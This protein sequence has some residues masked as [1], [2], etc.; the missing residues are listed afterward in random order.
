MTVIAPPELH[1]EARAALIRREVVARED[2]DWERHGFTSAERRDWTRAG[3]PE[4]SAHLAAMC[5]DSMRRETS[6][7]RLTPQALARRV[8][9][10]RSPE[11]V[12]DALLAGTN[13]LR[14]E[15]RLAS[16]QGTRPSGH[17]ED[18]LVVTV[19][20]ISSAAQNVAD[21]AA[22]FDS[23]PTGRTSVPAL[24][25]ASVALVR[26]ARPVLEAHARLH[27]EGDGFL[28]GGTVGPL[29]AEYARIHGVFHPDGDLRLLCRG[30][31]RR[32]A[33][34]PIRIRAATIIE[35]AVASR[36]SVFVTAEASAAASDFLARAAGGTISGDFTLPHEDGIAVVEPRRS[37]AG[38][39]IPTR[40]VAW[41]TLDGRTDAVILTREK[42]R[43]E[44]THKPGKPTSIR[45][46]RWSSSAGEPDSAVRLLHLLAA[47]PG[48]PATPHRDSR[49]T[50]RSPE[51]MGESR[52]SRP[53]GDDVVLV[54][55]PGPSG[56]S[57]R[58]S[59]TSEPRPP[60]HRWTVRAHPRNQWYPAHA[61]HRRIWI[62]E[63]ESGPA[64]MPLLKRQR[65]TVLAKTTAS[66]L[67]RR[68]SAS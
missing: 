26:A 21:A 60:D 13:A 47:R 12:L 34:F 11:T 66:L 29:L 46:E 49:R 51:P 3:M 58:A 15:Q 68:V 67:S 8:G 54:Y 20:D 45:I 55:A 14:T 56:S 44:F 22:R 42:L 9:D 24:A 6:P 5:R 64:G 2:D 41:S 31:P 61:E 32:G 25:D 36:N 10:R 1:P 40:I 17:S 65:V 52:R 33:D 53:A 30:L 7:G 50:N 62:D 19:P 39:A 28:A 16:K 57:T 38:D 59:R 48:S 27:D 18:M 23:I 63:H 4:T 43:L 35:R 37:E